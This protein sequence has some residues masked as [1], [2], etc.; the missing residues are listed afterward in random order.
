MLG[1]I[2]A[3]QHKDER[4]PMTVT[5]YS[6][7]HI[8]FFAC[9]LGNLVWEGLE[10][11]LHFSEICECKVVYPWWKVWCCC[12][13]VLDASWSKVL[14]KH[15]H[16]FC[17]TGSGQKTCWDQHFSQNVLTSVH[18]VHIPNTY[19]G[20]A[21]LC[22]E[23]LDFGCACCM[24]GRPMYTQRLL[25]ALG[26]ILCMPGRIFFALRSQRPTC[27]FLQT[28]NAMNSNSIT[29]GRS[30]WQQGQ[31]PSAWGWQATGPPPVHSDIRILPL[32]LLASMLKH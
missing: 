23:L 28:T 2:L 17:T 29:E 19:M 10:L 14:E 15:A 9:V 18:T 26:F 11:F 1:T 27:L 6:L 32:M 5:F 13:V 22:G 16:S 3:L 8:V 20:T 31:P 21:T 12:T 24:R 25:Q 7:A 4:S 30:S